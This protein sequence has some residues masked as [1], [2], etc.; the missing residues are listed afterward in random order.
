MVR[1]PSLQIISV[2][3]ARYLVQCLVAVVRAMALYQSSQPCA[4]LWFNRSQSGRVFVGRTEQVPAVPFQI[5][6]YGQFPVK[7]RFKGLC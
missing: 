6:K 2:E 4:V 5:K 3:V 1:F 7:I